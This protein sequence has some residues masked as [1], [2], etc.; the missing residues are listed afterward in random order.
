MGIG[1]LDLIWSFLFFQRQAF[2]WVGKSP[3]VLL[4]VETKMSQAIFLVFEQGLRDLVR[5]RL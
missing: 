1:E 2:Q 5:W 3:N 4:A